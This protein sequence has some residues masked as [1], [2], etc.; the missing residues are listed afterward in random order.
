M[1]RA[2]VALLGLA[3]PVG[4]AAAQ[5]RP[6]SARQNLA[7]LAYVLGESH[8]LRQICAGRGTDYYWYGRMKQLLDVEASDQALQARLANSFNTGYAAGKARFPSC[9]KALKA[10]ASKLALR[11][12]ALA[13]QLAKP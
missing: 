11:G 3:L 1:R 10:E 5:D 4:T 7:E 13:D 8:A 6:P 2:L 9:G 12:Q